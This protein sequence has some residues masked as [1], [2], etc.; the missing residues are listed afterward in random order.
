MKTARDTP[1]GSNENIKIN[2]KSEIYFGEK[3][4]KEKYLVKHGLSQTQA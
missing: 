2:W 1:K 4:G 3:G